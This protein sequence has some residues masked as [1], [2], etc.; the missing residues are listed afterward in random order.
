MRK[1]VLLASIV[2]AI[3]VSSAQFVSAENAVGPSRQSHI[4]CTAEG[5]DAGYCAKYCLAWILNYA[6]CL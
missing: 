2:G 5:K 1:L 4:I 3:S 6:L